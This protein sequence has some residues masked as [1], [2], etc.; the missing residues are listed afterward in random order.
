MRRYKGQGRAAGSGLRVVVSKYNDLRT[1]I[2]SRTA[3]LARSP[4]PASRER[5]HRGRVPGAFEI[6][7][8]AQHAP[9]AAGST[10][11]SAS[12]A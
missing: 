11:S 9:R 4:R 6:P 1:P 8:A 2:A 3:A 5:H 12:A 10:R 7:L